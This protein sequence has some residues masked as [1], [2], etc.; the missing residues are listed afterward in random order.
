M[1][2]SKVPALL[3][4]LISVFVCL[5]SGTIGNLYSKKY[6][7][8]I[9]DR[10][11]YGMITQSFAAIVLFVF[12]GF[13]LKCSTYTIVLAICFGAITVIQSLSNLSALAI[14]PWSYTTVIGSVSTVIT[15]LSGY[16]FWK[17]E[18]TIT[19]VIGVALMVLCL[20]LAVSNDNNKKKASF[21]WLFYALVSSLACAAVGLLQKLHQN[22]DYE[23]ELSQFL[24]I[25]FISSFIISAI[26]YIL[27]NKSSKSENDLLHK[28]SDKKALLFGMVAVGVFIAMNNQFNL[29]LVGTM[30]SVVFFPMVNGGGLILSVLASSLL[31]KEKLLKRQRIGVFIGIV[32]TFLLCR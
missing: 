1:D 31:F 16:L 23:D 9:K 27:C 13:T 15:A 25:A 22:S 19:K 4:L 24:I 21:R 26:L 30:D 11:L 12:S 6:I 10:F 28:M 7:S 14:G 32:A 3:L 5:I 20:S 8:G 18:L 2:Y 29:F 17:E